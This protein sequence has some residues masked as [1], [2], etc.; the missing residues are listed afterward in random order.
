MLLS[1]E[2][3]S[4]SS[5]AFSDVASLGISSANDFNRPPNLRSVMVACLHIDSMDLHASCLCLT[6][7]CDKSIC[8]TTIS[9]A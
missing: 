6:S 7:V 5:K 8:E 9:E 4:S 2:T 1:F 3:A